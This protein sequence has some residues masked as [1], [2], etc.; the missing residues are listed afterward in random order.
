M[1]DSTGGVGGAGAGG[2][3]NVHG[4]SDTHDTRGNDGAGPADASGASAAGTA[5]A[6]APAGGTAASAQASEDGARAHPEAHFSSEA[7]NP[8][9]PTPGQVDSLT[10]ANVATPMSMQA[11]MSAISQ[12]TAAVQKAAESA[13]AIGFSPPS[14]T[15]QA[16][17]SF[18]IANSPATAD[19]RP[20]V[21]PKTSL[22]ELGPTFSQTVDADK[23]SVTITMKNPGMLAAGDGVTVSAVL[24]DAAAPKKTGVPGLDVTAAYD[25]ALAAPTQEEAAKSAPAQVPGVHVGLGLTAVGTPD[26]AV[27]AEAVLKGVG[28]SAEAKAGY[29]FQA[30][31]ISLDG[32]LSVKPVDVVAHQDWTANGASNTSVGVQY[33]FTD[34]FWAKVEVRNKAGAGSS[35]Y[36]GFGLKGKF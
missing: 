11:Q 7:P 34:N 19:G 35:F 31:A 30:K 8:T 4:S 25:S 32:K 27:N 23:P 29:N 12:T 9:G 24:H 21:D 20:K 22:G 13:A 18:S 33:N 15:A 17:S 16:A 14:E 10:H 5:Q 28:W 26:M 3:A 6:S 1:S 2:G 36:G